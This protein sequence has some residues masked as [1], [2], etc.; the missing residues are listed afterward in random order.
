MPDPDAEPAAPALPLPALP[1]PEAPPAPNAPANPAPSDPLAPLEPAVIVG[2]APPTGAPPAGA[3][4]VVAGAPEA[5]FEPPPLPF[6]GI[7]EAVPHATNQTAQDRG[8]SGR[9]SRIRWSTF[10]ISHKKGR[11][12]VKLP[13]IVAGAKLHGP[14]PLSQG[15]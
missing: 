2:P 12:G 7:C 5:A 9:R 6:G 3:P 8:A 1:E 10:L 4:P 13:R 14:L 11:G 15:T